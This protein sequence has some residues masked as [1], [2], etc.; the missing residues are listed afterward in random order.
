MPNVKFSDEIKGEVRAYLDLKWSSGQIISALK[1]R[2][3]NISRS[4]ISR[5]RKQQQFISH[6]RLKRAHKRPDIK[7]KLSKNDL[8]NLRTLLT[9][10]NP[11]TQRSLAKKFRV[12]QMTIRNYITKKLNLRCLKKSKVHKLTPQAIEKRAKRSFALYRRLNNEKWRKFLTTD[13]AFFSLDDLDR[14]SEFQYLI[15][16]RKEQMDLSIRKRKVFP[17]KFWFQLV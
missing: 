14:P 10:E 5:I 9:Q 13:E 1:Q 7:P 4:T 15:K 8:K 11:P 12:S 2:K 6:D 3:I 16:E 17:P